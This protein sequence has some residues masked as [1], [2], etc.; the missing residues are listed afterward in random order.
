LKNKDTIIYGNGSMAKVLFSYAKNSINICSFT[1]D[2][3]CINNDTEIFCGKPLI[4]FSKVHDVF[5]PNNHNIIIAVG[6]LDMNELREQKQNEAL[7]RGYS[8][9]GYRHESV[10]I[11]EDV[12][13]ED[14]CIILDFVS[15]HPGSKIGCGTFISSNVNIGHTCNIGEFNWI[16]S[17]VTVAGGCNTGKGCFFGVNS[18]VSHGVKIADRNFISANTLVNKDTKD[19]DVYLTAQGELSKMKSKFFLKF[20]KII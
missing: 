12:L 16:S 15:I 10:H 9:T 17:G 5:K 18:S 1:V 3:H 14:N 2:D 19:D 8:L 20:A 7:N 11:H 4:P 6:F 13:I